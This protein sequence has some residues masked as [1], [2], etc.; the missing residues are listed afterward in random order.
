MDLATDARKA[1][2]RQYARAFDSFGEL[3]M[4]LMAEGRY[5]E[6]AG[7]HEYALRILRAYRGEC[8]A[9]ER[10][11]TRDVSHDRGGD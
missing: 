4:Q 2:I 11:A 10:P 7:A 9:A 6:A 5:T 8:D 3:E 1:V